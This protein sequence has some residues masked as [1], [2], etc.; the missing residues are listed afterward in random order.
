MKNYREVYVFLGAGLGLI[1]ILALLSLMLVKRL[2]TPERVK[3]ELLAYLSEK[4]GGTVEFNKVEINFFPGPH[5][6]LKG[7][8]FSIPDR[9]DGS[10][11]TLVVYPRALPLLKGEFDV[12]SLKI[13]KP[14]IKLLIKAYCI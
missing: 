5:V 8:T 10:F 7:G 13:I 14:V 12:S 3:A 6:V 4:I 2:V 1:I 11:E 9:L